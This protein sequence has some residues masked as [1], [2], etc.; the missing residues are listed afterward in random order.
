VP[1][2][3]G[4]GQGKRGLHVRHVMNMLLTCRCGS[5]LRTCVITALFGALVGEHTCVLLFERIHTRAVIPGVL[6]N[7]W[8]D[9]CGI[10]H[11]GC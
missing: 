1:V 7:A 9:A 6:C 5:R 10:V 2:R 8:R 4:V 3:G 11:V